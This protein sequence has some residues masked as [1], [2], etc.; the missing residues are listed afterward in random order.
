MAARVAVALL[1]HTASASQGGAIGTTP[2]RRPAEHVATAVIAE[3]R[4]AEHQQ[5]FPLKKG[6]SPDSPSFGR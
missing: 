4:W 3:G 2:E 5:S 6:Y 1:K